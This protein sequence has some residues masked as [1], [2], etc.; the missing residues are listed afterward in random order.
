MVNLTEKK[1]EV[2]KN[3]VT[4]TFFCCNTFPFFGDVFLLTA[5]LIEY[6][7]SSIQ[8][9]SVRLFEFKIPPC[10]HFALKMY[11]YAGCAHEVDVFQKLMFLKL[12][13]FQILTKMNV[14]LKENL[15]KT[16]TEI[17]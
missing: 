3:T 11:H 10:K 17:R 6:Y 4:R 2:D 5:V 9:S 12:L 1:V 15:I 14:Y 8:F 7:Y 16:N 13:V